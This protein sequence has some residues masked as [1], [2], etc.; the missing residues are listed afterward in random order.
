MSLTFTFDEVSTV[1]MGVEVIWPPDELDLP[2][3]PSR[4]PQLQ[5]IPGRAGPLLTGV[6][7]GE[8]VLTVPLSFFAMTEAGAAAKV[9]AI[10]A[11]LL[12]ETPRA[13]RLSHEPDKEYYAVCVPG[14]LTRTYWADDS[15]H[16]YML[17]VQFVAPDPLAYDVDETATAVTDGLN[18]IANGGGRE[19]FPRFEL[20]LDTKSTGLEILNATSGV[21]FRLG[22]PVAADEVAYDPEE[23]VFS[24]DCSSLSGWSVSEVFEAG[25]VAGTMG[26]VSSDFAP[27]DY[28]SG[29]GLHGPAVQKTV[30]DLLDDFRIDVSINFA[31]DPVYYTAEELIAGNALMGMIDICGLTGD[32]DVMCRFGVYDLW[33]TMRQVQFY[34]RAGDLSTGRYLWKGLPADPRA[35]TDLTPGLVRIQRIGVNWECYIGRWDAAL[36]QYVW[37]LRKGFPDGEGLYTGQLAS[38][39]I[40]IAKQSSATPPSQRV[41]SIAVY[42]PAGDD[43][44]GGTVPYV[45]VPNIPIVIDMAEPRRVTQ[46][47]ESII[48]LD[49]FSNGYFPLGTGS[50]DVVIAADEG[51]GVSG[52]AYLRECWD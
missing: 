26:I 21:S 50:S 10:A 42:E 38:V 37:Q 3:A 23:P 12:T 27:T 48:H 24:E 2:L 28:G 32:G 15:H 30:G 33:P 52:F 39:N 18:V 34:A 13:L 25:T 40:A 5:P 46:G 20:V 9:R 51:V 7:T 19:A 4:T 44:A 16:R 47:G 36:G 6:D 22:N 43:S 31:D 29:T 49:N 17:P 1:T 35:W 45:L 41:Q 11:W 14:S 8:R